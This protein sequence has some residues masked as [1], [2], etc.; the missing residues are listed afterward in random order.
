[1]GAPM[2]TSKSGSCS[3]SLAK[4]VVHW[5]L[6]RFV[7]FAPSSTPQ[8]VGIMNAPLHGVADPVRTHGL[9]RG[10]VVPHDWHQFVSVPGIPLH[11]RAHTA[12]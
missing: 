11:E 2:S 3:S 12:T 8:R 10:D 9:L 6:P 4:A 1:M 5:C 7:R